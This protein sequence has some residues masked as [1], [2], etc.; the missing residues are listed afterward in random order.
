M[1]HSVKILASKILILAIKSHFSD[2]FK[3][4]KNFWRY[5]GKQL[6]AI[7]QRAS[8]TKVLGFPDLQFGVG[9]LWVHNQQHF[10]FL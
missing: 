7:D 3:S 9:E 4:L 10:P 6:D 2:F 5:G 1:R 8:E